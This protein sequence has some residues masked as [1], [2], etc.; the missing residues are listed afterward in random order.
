MKDNFS[1]DR[2]GGGGGS[3]GN[4]SDGGMAQA[5]MRVMGSDRRS[6]VLACPLLTSCCAAWFLTGRGP[7]VGD[8]CAK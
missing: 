2:A 6:L 8:P 3:G 5:V 7:G 1:T 4:V